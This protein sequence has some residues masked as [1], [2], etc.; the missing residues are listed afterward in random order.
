[1]NR[2]VKRIGIASIVL[3]LVL[4]AGCVSQ[5]SH[6]GMTFEQDCNDLSKTPTDAKK[7]H[8]LHLAAITSAYLDTKSMP[9]TNKITGA[10]EQVL[11]SQEAD[12]LCEDIYYKVGINLG[13]D[14]KRKAWTEMQSCYNSIA[15]ITGNYV[16]CTKIKDA[17]WYDYSITGSTVLQDVCI[18]NADSIQE[19]NAA[20]FVNNKNSLCN[21]VFIFPAIIA[22]AFIMNNKRKKTETR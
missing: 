9:S 4:F 10:P 1:M 22:G 17:S 14:Q 12:R 18:S 2:I 16:Y 21:L 19:R 13:F 15:K 20:A 6:L 3:L 5:N 7:V 8:C 11:W